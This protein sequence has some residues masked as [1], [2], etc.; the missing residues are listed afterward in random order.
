MGAG[1]MWGLLE[2][3]VAVECLGTVAGE[4]KKSKADLQGLLP[5]SE[6]SALETFFS[7]TVEAAGTSP[8]CILDLLYAPL[9]P[10]PPPPSPPPLFIP[11]VRSLVDCCICGVSKITYATAV[12][13]I[14]GQLPAKTGKGS[15]GQ[16]IVGG[17]FAESGLPM[18]A[19]FNDLWTCS[20]S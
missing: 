2:R 6:Y 16:C 5:A 17:K 19:H 18:D 4:L 14:A 20:P 1:N 3:T 11:M 15:Q 13:L 7:R 9:I 8:L 10:P 12:L